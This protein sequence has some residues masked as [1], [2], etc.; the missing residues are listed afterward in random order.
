MKRIEEVAKELLRRLRIGIQEFGV[1]EEAGLT[2]SEI[3]AAVDELQSCGNEI[4][5]FEDTIRLTGYRAAQCGG[6]P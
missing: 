4:L 1:L 2:R 6:Q 3:L 5:I